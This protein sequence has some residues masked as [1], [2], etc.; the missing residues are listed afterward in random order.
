MATL[1]TRLADGPSTDGRMT[2]PPAFP[3]TARGRWR[4][5]ADAS[6]TV[7]VDSFVGEV[8]RYDTCGAGPDY[9]ARRGHDPLWQ[10]EITW[11]SA[12][13]SSRNP[14]RTTRS[15][16][17][18]HIRHTSASPLQSGSPRRPRESP[19]VRSSGIRDNRSHRAVGRRVRATA[20]LATRTNFRRASAH[21][22]PAIDVAPVAGSEQC[23]AP[24]LDVCDSRP[25]ARTINDTRR[26]RGDCSPFA[27]GIARSRSRGRIW[28]LREERR[29]PETM[30]VEQTATIRVAQPR[31]RDR[32]L[33][34]LTEGTVMRISHP[35]KLRHGEPPSYELQ[36]GVGRR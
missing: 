9:T 3:A 8:H 28:R 11:V 24:T 29:V 14:H 33:L 21:R 31:L 15:D 35:R 32:F 4:S 7:D 30:W 13:P 5:P 27:G 10:S 6:L 25:N 36:L 1:I 2:R 17:R 12:R 26:S 23:W 22:S 20:P 16:L 18:R 19:A 34:A